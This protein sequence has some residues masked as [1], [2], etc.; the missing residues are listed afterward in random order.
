[1]YKRQYESIVGQTNALIDAFSVDEESAAAGEKI[2]ERFEALDQNIEAAKEAFDG[3]TVMV[4]QSSGDAHYIQTENGTLGSMAAMIGFENVYTNDQSSM[5]Q[6]DYEQALD[7]DPDIV[8]CVGAEDAEGHKAV[9]YTH[10]DVYKRQCRD[11]TNRS[12][13]IARLA[14]FIY[15][16]TRSFFDIMEGDGK[17]RYSVG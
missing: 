16:G 14:D 12:Q 3:K 6:L 9:S 1:M 5:V 2:R 13:R 4:L 8:M 11:R 7:Y 10:L 15:P 17:K